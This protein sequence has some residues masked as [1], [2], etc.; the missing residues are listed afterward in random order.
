MEHRGGYNRPVGA[1]G[2][3]FFELVGARCGWSR[4][5]VA[6]WG[7]GCCFGG[8][9]GW[10]RDRSAGFWSFGPI[11]EP[12]QA[13]DGED[14]GDVTVAAAVARAHRGVGEGGRVGEA[15]GADAQHTG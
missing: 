1:F 4:L 8:G 3:G 9:L 13:E 5:R 15:P 10:G 14:E 11:A 6:V 2:A 7:A 12:E